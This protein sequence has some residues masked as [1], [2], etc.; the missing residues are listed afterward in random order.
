MSKR[1]ST[2]LPPM[3]VNTPDALEEMSYRLWAAPAIAVD[4]E[5]NSLYAYS[6]RVCL[7]QFSVPGQD[8]LVDA[9]ALDDL[10]A[11]GPILAD[12]EIVKVFHAAEYDVMVLRRDYAFTFANLF[13]TM[14]ASR[15]VGWERYGLAALLEERFGIL[16]D[17]RMQRTNW[18][19]RPLTEEQIEYARLDTR[20]LLQLRDDLLVEL[21][22]QGR[23]EEARGAFERVALSEWSK[24][25]F[26]PDDFWRIRGAR[27][28]DEQGLAV[29]RALY[30]HREERARELDRPPFKVLSDRVLVALSRRTPRSFAELGRIKGL[31][32]R[33]PS[34]ERRNLLDV[35]D[36]GLGAPVPTR[37]A[38]GGSNYDEEER[39]RYEALR[40]WRKARAE[41][42]GVEPDVILSNRALHVLANQNP[43][44]PEELDA[45]GVLNDWERREYGREIITLLRRQARIRTY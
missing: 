45:T 20:F 36:R 40:E 21:E 41:A 12:D 42:R 10:S 6:E 43:S 32:R 22:E 11:L 24:R 30:I 14:I 35:V 13:D 31:P 7:I 33:L 34:G 2:L 39:E 17:K 38:R 27:D 23:L 8:Y 15:I 44:S 5:S 1:K 16:T 19:R 18:G 4:T 9:L 29:L 25:E 26:D 3:L 28:L 37:P